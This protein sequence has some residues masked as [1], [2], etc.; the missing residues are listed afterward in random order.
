MFFGEFEKFK[1]IKHPIIFMGNYI[2][3]FEK[4]FYKDS[5]FRGVILTLS[6]LFVVFVITFILA[7]VDSLLFQA[8]LCSFTLAGKMLFEVVR[9]VVSSDD[10]DT[11]RG[12]IAMLVSRDTTSLSDSDVNKAAVETYAENLS[13]GLIAPLFYLICFGIVGAYL[14]KAINTLD[15]MVGYRNEKYEKFGKFSA[16]LDD[17]VNY[18][19]ARITAILIAILFRSK[20][21]FLKFKE[22]G[23]KHDSP[24]AGLPISAMALSCGIKLGGPTSYFGKIKNKPFF[25]EGR[26]E[27]KSSDVTN[28]TSLKYRLDMLVIVLLGVLSVL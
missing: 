6:L 15:S 14:Y 26:E 19:P 13:D 9:D 24:N 8:F 21:A 22:Y 1:F 11:K 12:K 17:F 20:K 28:V 23:K 3:W 2:S 16:K 7:Q 5:V 25:G 18:I 10:L 27:I 4:K